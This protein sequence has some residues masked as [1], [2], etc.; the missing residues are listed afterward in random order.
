MHMTCDNLIIQTL[1]KTPYS[2]IF[3]ECCNFIISNIVNS[4]D[5]ITNW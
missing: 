1:S 2:D 3:M 4:I 5:N